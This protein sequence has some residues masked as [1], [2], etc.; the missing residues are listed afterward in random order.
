M[1]IGVIWL[2]LAGTK[3]I[4]VL[5][6]LSNIFPGKQKGTSKKGIELVHELKVR[7]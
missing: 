6:N 3:I 4:H 7:K 1:V 2:V 5:Q